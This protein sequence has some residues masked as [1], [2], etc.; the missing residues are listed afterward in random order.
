MKKTI[1]WLIACIFVSTVVNAQETVIDP[2]SKSLSLSLEQVKSYAS[3][4]NR[5]IQKSE[6]AYKQSEKTKWAAIANY[7][8]SATA[9][10]TYNNSLGTKLEIFG[11]V[12]TMAPSSTMTIQV[13]QPILNMSI[14]AGTQIAEVA[15]QMSLNAIE[16]T[17][18][19]IKQNV[20]TTYYSILVLEY[21]RDILKKNLENVKVLANATNMKVKV[22]IGQQTEADQMDITV[23]N[24]ENTIQSTNRNIEM[25]Y[26]TLRLL[27]G[28]EAG[29]QIVLTS[30]LENLTDRTNTFDLLM[31]PFD[32]TNN[33]DMKT[34]LL[35]V[36]LYDK[37][38]KS[39]KYAILPTLTGIYQHNEILMKSG[40]D[41][42]MKNTLVV[43][44]SLPLFAS[45][46]NYVNIKKAKLALESSKL[47]KEQAEDQLLI[48]EKQLRYNLKSAQESFELQ[49]KNIEVSQR[50]FDN[51]TK[52][53]D[54]GLSSSIEL[55]TANNNLLTAQSNYVNS[56]MTLLSSQDALQKLL[57]TL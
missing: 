4:H 1:V 57:G 34:S 33:I 53:Y 28:A 42:T 12:I 30:K 8:P 54:Q 36:E 32:V 21:S 44:A 50:V 41:F 6:I 16:Q 31:K 46:K 39:A 25:A 26:N 17:E 5:M 3:E 14:I 49:K 10:A 55:I 56:V 20:S 35:N 48:Q 13:A 40:L 11:Q 22:G 2:G 19:S 18:L 45:G 23:A 52:K 15:R 24:L 9:S 47:D 27:I 29:D 37:Q 43:S 7:M 51:I 38:L